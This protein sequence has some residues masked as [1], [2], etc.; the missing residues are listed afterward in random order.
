LYSERIEAVNA[1]ESNY[2]HQNCNNMESGIYFAR[3]NF[4][5]KVQ[6]IKFTVAK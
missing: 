2:Q 3:V 5:D 6:T 4:G 1:G